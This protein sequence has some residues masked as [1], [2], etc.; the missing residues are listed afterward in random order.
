[1]KGVRLRQTQYVYR[2]NAEAKSPLNNEQTLNE[3]LEHKIGGRAR[4]MNREI[5]W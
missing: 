2:S 1:V 5:G 3:G 4:Y